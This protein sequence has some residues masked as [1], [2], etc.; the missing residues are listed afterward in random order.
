LDKS[1]S[2]NVLV[3]HTGQVALLSKFDPKQTPDQ[4]PTF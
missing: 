2:K 1:Y 3:V 4:S